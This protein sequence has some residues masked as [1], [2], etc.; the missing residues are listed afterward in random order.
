[1][2][3]VSN[4]T[5]LYGKKYGI[6]DVSFTVKKGEICGFVGQNGAG[7][8]TAIRTLMNMIFPT[9]GAA[10]IDGLDCVADAK[11]VKRAVGYVPG[12]VAY[13]EGSRVSAILSYAAEFA[14]GAQ[15]EIAGLCEYFELDTSRRI[16]ELSLGNRKKVG[17]VQALIKNPR[18]MILDEPTNGLDPLIQEKL[19]KLLREKRDAGMTVFLSSHNLAE[20]EKYCDRVLIIKDGA[21][22]DEFDLNERRK[23]SKLKVA[24]TTAD[25]KNTVLSYG[26]DINELLKTLSAKKITTITITPESLEE[27]FM[28]YYYTGT[29]GAEDEKL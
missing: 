10:R 22:V 29:Q 11:L 24:Y 21:I 8:S 14:D 27:E 26:G 3:A 20:V 18:L 25:G 5:K 15:K 9:D 2:I 19:F 6:K 13:Y 28:K 23:N 12:E 16:S 4:L 17:I 1:M 7:K